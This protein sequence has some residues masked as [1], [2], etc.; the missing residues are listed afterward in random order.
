MLHGVTDV[1]H[2]GR[3]G[4]CTRRGAGVLRG[5]AWGWAAGEPGAGVR[6]PGRADPGREAPWLGGQKHRTL[7]NMWAGRG[8]FGPLHLP[9]SCQLAASNNKTGGP[10]L[11]SS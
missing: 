3:T 6:P 7:Q 8:H 4:V 2:G 10:P 9:W 1:Q 5:E 11:Y